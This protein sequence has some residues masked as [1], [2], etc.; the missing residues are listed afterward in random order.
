MLMSLKSTV[1]H[2]RATDNIRPGSLIEYEY[3]TDSLG[4]KIARALALVIDV[5]RVPN[6]SRCKLTIIT[7]GPDHGSVPLA[8]V[9]QIIII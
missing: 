3:A 8:K 6:I 5:H 2:V 7:P 9:T 4:I 1:I